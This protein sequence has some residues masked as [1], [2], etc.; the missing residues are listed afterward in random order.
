MHSLGVAP[1]THSLPEEDIFALEIKQ[2]KYRLYAGFESEAELIKVS[3]KI[4][5]LVELVIGPSTGLI[6]G[7]VRLKKLRN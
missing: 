5:N 2:G 6:H 4:M 1:R 7:S 3:E